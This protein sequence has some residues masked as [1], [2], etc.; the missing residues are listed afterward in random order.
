VRASIGQNDQIAPG[1]LDCGL[2]ALHFELTR[3]GGS[4]G[5][6]RRPAESTRRASTCIEFMSQM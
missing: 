2:D 6:R 1:E 3:A 4:K 5:E